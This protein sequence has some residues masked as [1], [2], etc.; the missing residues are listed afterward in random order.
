[1]Y[2]ISLYSEGDLSREPVLIDVPTAAE[3]SIVYGWLKREFSD[4]FVQWPADA[5][6]E[7]QRAAEEAEAKAEAARAAKTVP[8]LVYWK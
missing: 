2:Q 3:L 7:A 8:R 4:A 1:M 6:A 5:A